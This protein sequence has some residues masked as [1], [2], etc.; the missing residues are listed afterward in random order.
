[1]FDITERERPLGLNP[2]AGVAAEQ[3]SLAASELLA[4]FR[5]YFAD[6]WGARLEHV[7]RNVV[8][9]LLE[10]E[11][12]TMADIPRLLSDRHYLDS[13]LS[14]VTNPAVREFF[15]YEYEDVLHR[16][17]D[18][19]EPILN[20]VGPWLVY[21][22][23][24]AII[25]QP[26]SSFDFRRVIDEGR[27]LFVRIP[28]GALGEDISNLLGALVVAK[29]QLA[30]QSR[31]NLP[32]AARRPFYLYVD[33]FQNF[34]TSAFTKI[35]TEARGFNL[36][37]VCANQYAEQL[38]RELQ[39]AVQRNAATF[40]KAVQREGR[41]SLEVMR[42]EDLDKKKP[43]VFAVSAYGPPPAGDV[44]WAEEVRQASRLRYGR[45]QSGDIEPQVRR[46]ESERSPSR[47][48]RQDVDEE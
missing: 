20:K 26:Q 15:R 14:Q 8:L 2:L 29:L 47:T 7:L 30:A 1:L 4:V 23:L 31:V 27:V 13:V 43:P 25:D 33:E 41:H 44:A 42:Q 18:V 28:Q 5:R 48:T 17:G 19:V 16:R 35:L 34:A 24:R 10:T 38:P 40:V 21:P 6:A 3:R 45:A 11:G 46:P 37:L 32:Q 36:S 9:A 12:A 22:E 39:Q